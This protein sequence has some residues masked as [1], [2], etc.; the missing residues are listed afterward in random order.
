MEG[1]HKDITI[2]ARF[3]QVD[4]S[5]QAPVCPNTGLPK[6]ARGWPISP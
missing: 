2:A 1:P 6:A 5:R 3:V 4:V